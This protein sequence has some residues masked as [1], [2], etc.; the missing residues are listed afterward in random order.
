[1][2]TLKGNTAC[3]GCVIGTP[4][5]VSETGDLHGIGEGD[6]LV[7]KET[8]QDYT[9]A[10]MRAAGVVTERGGRFCHAALFARETQTPTLLGVAGAREALAK[11][12]RIKLDATSG[13][14]TWEEE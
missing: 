9:V 4:R 10:M 8:D 1:M 12:S 2:K 3:P 14:I 13:E 7:A 6:I 11:V 5:I